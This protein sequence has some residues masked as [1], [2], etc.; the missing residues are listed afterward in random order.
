MSEL[1]ELVFQTEST[2]RAHPLVGIVDAQAKLLL[3][4]AEGL[5]LAPAARQRIRLPATD[6]GD[7][8][9]ITPA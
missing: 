6:S 1:K 2:Q 7:W 4:L 9:S 5:G 8:A 3:T